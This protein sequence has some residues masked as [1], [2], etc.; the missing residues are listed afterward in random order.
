M[1]C[2]G[3]SAPRWLPLANYL[4]VCAISRQERL[5]TP[6]GAM[7][8]VRTE[9]CPSS[10]RCAMFRCANEDLDLE[11]THRACQRASSNHPM[12][13]GEK[14]P[15]GLCSAPPSCRFSVRND[16]VAGIVRSVRAEHPLPEPTMNLTDEGGLVERSGF[17]DSPSRS[18]VGRRIAARG[19]ARRRDSHEATGA[20]RHGSDLGSV[21]R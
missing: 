17:P 14:R 7:A 5:G 4:P 20:D 11:F 16:Q 8:I 6:M 19:D 2:R 9:R 21:G 12:P 3:T 10:S 13:D 15:S 18:I 1:E